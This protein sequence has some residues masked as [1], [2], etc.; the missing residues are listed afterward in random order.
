MFRHTATFRFYEELNDFLPNEKRK[1]PFQY[2]FNKSPSLKDAV[3]AIGVPHVEIE[4]LLVNGNSVN[5]DY[6]LKDKDYISVYPVFESIDISEVSLINKA[7]LRQIK[8]ILDV[9]L[10]KLAKYLRLFGFDSFYSNDFDDFQI[11]ELALEQ[12]RIILTRDKGLLKVKSV[13]HGYW[14]RNE[15][16]KLQINEV[17]RRF[18][19]MKIINPFSRCIECNGNIFKV[20]KKEI[21]HELKAMTILNFNEFYQCGTCKKIYWEGSHFGRM[22]KFINNLVNE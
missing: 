4:L 3:E 22:Q 7:P 18:D 15:D 11:I 16:P 13:T 20:D 2:C 6:L 8:F 17:I 19:L 9:H 21:E 14:I 10:G 5:F 12:K 1:V